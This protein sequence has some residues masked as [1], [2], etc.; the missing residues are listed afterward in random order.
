MIIAA[1][2]SVLVALL[3]AHEIKG[4]PIWVSAPPHYAAYK[5][6]IE[7][8]NQQHPDQQFG[9]HL[10]HGRAQERRM[11][12]GFLSGTPVADLIEVQLGIAAKAFLGPVEEVGFY[13]LTDRLHAEGLYAQINQ[14]SF[15]PY[16][17]R[18]RIFGIPHDVHPVLL[19]YRSDIVE[20]AGIDVSKIETW[21][22]YFRILKPLMRDFDGDG[23]PDRYL[24]TADATRSDVI[25]MLIAQAGGTLFDAHDHLTLNNPINA[26]VLAK[27]ITWT[28]GP[29]KTSIEV[30]ANTAA[31]HRQRLEGLVIGSLVPD[32]MAGQW[33][34]ENPGLAG[35]MKLMPI[36]AWEKG[37]RRTSVVGGTMMGISKTSENFDAAWALTKFLY[38]SPALAERTY[39]TAS[40]ISPVKA[41]W[42]LPVYDEPDPFFSGQPSGR[43]FIEQAPHVPPRPSSPYNETAMQ[44]LVTVAI[45]LQAYA[46]RHGIY[47]AE[48]LVPEAQRLLDHAQV[49][50][51]KLISRNVF[52]K[53]ENP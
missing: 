53:E 17:S 11:L 51:Q 14:P 13:D 39:R 36:P 28:T 33:K 46:E 31:G 6:L 8:W 40:I 9:L 49:A 42:S 7:T 19:A 23:R 27:M 38:T 18:G 22:D 48:K 24:F 32:W 34:I 30:G 12:A 52:L 26:R 2:T 5:P 1:V 35:K 45:A 47:D 44:K 4:I 41:L 50:L 16:T 3:P 29:D 37:G 20:A 21:D 10:L 43:L 15:A 25:S